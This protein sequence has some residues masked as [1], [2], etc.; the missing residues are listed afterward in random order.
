MFGK[1]IN[2]FSIAGF[3]IGIDLSW[4]FIAIILSWTLAAGY[5]PI[6]YPKQ[7]P[8]T[9]WLMGIFGMIGLFIC[10][11]LHELGH[12]CVAR[13][14]GLPI[15]YIT[16]FIFGGVAEL[17]KEPTSPKMEFLM[18]IAGPIVS[19][20]LAALFYLLAR[21]GIAYH[22][23]IAALGVISYLM[24]INFVLAIFNLIPAFP[25]DGGRV[26]RSILW[27]WKKDLAFATR[28]SAAIGSGFGFA[29]IFLGIFSFFVFR[30]FFAGIW[31]IIL[32]WFLHRA[33]ASV[34]TQY[35]ISKELAGEKVSKFMKRDPISVTSDISIKDFVEKFVYTSHHHLYPVTSGG[36]FLGYV[37]LQ[38]VKA[39]PH[40]D[41]NRTLIEKIMVHSPTIQT[42][43]PDTS[44][45]EILNTFQQTHHPILFVVDRGHLIGILTAQDLFKIISLKIELEPSENK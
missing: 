18:A 19:L 45:L 31:L 9:Y 2:I 28:V 35:Y 16:L 36:R 29:L 26:F 30:N 22:W 8:A 14:Y 27:G 5:F 39:I 7:P 15:T 32:G 10:V 23:H 37:S 3:K 24:F 4:F 41:W 20:V 42:V 1:R 43:S 25:L 40:A 17:K 6:L 34:Q 11:I 44:A 33:A 13:H 12:A 21:I 38:E